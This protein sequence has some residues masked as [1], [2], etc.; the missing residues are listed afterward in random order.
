MSGHNEN[1]PIGVINAVGVCCAESL[2][3]HKLAH[4]YSHP[5]GM[6]A[7]VGLQ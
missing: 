5:D 3:S 7:M 4:C 6:L 2:S 1:C